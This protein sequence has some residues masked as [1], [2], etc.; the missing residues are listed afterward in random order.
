MT[1]KRLALQGVDVET[2]AAA[3]SCVGC[4]PIFTKLGHLSRAE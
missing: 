1:G 4:S 2:P 3:K